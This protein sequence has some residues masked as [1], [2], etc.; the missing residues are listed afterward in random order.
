MGQTEQ[1]ATDGK[2]VSYYRGRWPTSNVPKFPILKK[3]ETLPPRYLL[4]ASDCFLRPVIYDIGM[5]L[6]NA[7]MIASFLGDSE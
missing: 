3:Q 4:Q 2:S 7:N 6:E 1:R 5:G